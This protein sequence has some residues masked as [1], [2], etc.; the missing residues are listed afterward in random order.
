MVANQEFLLTPITLSDKI[1]DGNHRIMN[2]HV[3]K[4]L[5][6][7]PKISRQ[8][9]IISLLMTKYRYSHDNILNS[10]DWSILGLRI[11]SL[12]LGRFITS[13]HSWQFFGLFFC[14]VCVFERHPRARSNEKMREV[15]GEF[16][17]RP[18]FSFCEAV[19]LTLPTTFNTNP[20]RTTN[21]K[22]IKKTASYAKVL[23]NQ[24][25][26]LKTLLSSYTPK[27]G[28]RGGGGKGLVTSSQATI[29]HSQVTNKWWNYWPLISTMCSGDL[30]ATINSL[31]DPAV[32]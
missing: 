27:R 4:K 24:T 11:D 7:T 31:G 2:I 15:N 18:R 20:V 30:C 3:N 22:H 19:F 29:L 17:F 10:S 8:C 23:Y 21:E 13:L 5:S 9:M 26:V 1:K 6:L 14:P 12:H 28:A 32:S 16:L 25:L